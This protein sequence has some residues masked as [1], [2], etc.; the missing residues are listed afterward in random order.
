M[1]DMINTIEKEELVYKLDCVRYEKYGQEDQKEIRTCDGQRETPFISEVVTL[2]KL[3]RN[4]PIKTGIT[5]LNV[6]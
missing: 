3:K 4:N 5:K 1:V 2:Q 6:T